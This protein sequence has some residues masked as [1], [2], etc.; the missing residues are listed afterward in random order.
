MSCQRTHWL[1]RPNAYRPCRNRTSLAAAY[2]D[3]HIATTHRASVHAHRALQKLC[4]VRR[5]KCQRG[6]FHSNDAVSRWPQV[7]FFAERQ[8]YADV[9]QASNGEIKALIAYVRSRA[10]D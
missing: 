3:Q 8:T 5:G 6:S 1:F 7:R 10:E 4:E 9:L 2:H